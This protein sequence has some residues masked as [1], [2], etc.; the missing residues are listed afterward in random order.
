MA[1]AQF[2]DEVLAEFYEY[3]VAAGGNPGAPA[4]EHKKDGFDKSAVSNDDEVEYWEDDGDDSETEEE[5]K[6][7]EEE[8]LEQAR[9]ELEYMNNMCKC[10]FIPKEFCS[11]ADNDDFILPPEITNNPFL[12]EPILKH[13]IKKK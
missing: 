6:K 11:A 9:E 8:E 2:A 4:Q 13:L 1:A 10:C 7:R 5:Q 12:C 3:D